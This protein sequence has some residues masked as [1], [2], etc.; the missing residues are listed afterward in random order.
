MTKSIGL[1]FCFAPMVFWTICTLYLM[2]ADI[3][4]HVVPCH[5]DYWQ[6]QADA[7]V[8]AIPIFLCLVLCT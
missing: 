6:N 8:F 2:Q 4:E 7:A 3:P 1:I 5:E